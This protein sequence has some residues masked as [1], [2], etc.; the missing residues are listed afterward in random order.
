[1][2]SLRR[3]LALTRGPRPAR[4]GGC[5]ALLGGTTAKAEERMHHRVQG[6]TTHVMSLAFAA[7]IAKLSIIVTVGSR[8]S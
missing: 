2:F 6:G 1:M 3:T 4:A 7:P 5:I 8:P